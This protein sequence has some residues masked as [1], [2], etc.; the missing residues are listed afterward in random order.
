MKQSINYIMC[1]IFFLLYTQP[2]FAEED[3]MCIDDSQEDIYNNFINGYYAEE[4]EK[5]HQSML[6]EV[7]MCRSVKD[8]TLVYHKFCRLDPFCLDSIRVYAKY[9]F[10]YS[11]EFDLD[12][13]LLAAIAMHESNYNASTVGGIGER[14]LFQLHPYSPWGRKSKFV[15]DKKYNKLCKSRIGHCQW[16]VTGIAAE[17]LRA[18]FDDL[19]RLENVLTIYNTGHAKPVRRIYVKSVLEIRK[20]LIENNKVINFCG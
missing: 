6:K 8:N 2:V 14:G 18:H 9:I 11:L 16:E 17:T 7:V 3:L 10:K 19:K 4:Q 5:L 15:S 13:W 12:P 20:R 1:I